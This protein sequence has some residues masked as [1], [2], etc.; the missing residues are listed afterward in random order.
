MRAVRRLRQALEK[1]ATG[2][3]RKAMSQ[4]EMAYDM[5]K[6]AR[7]PLHVSVIIERI[8]AAFGITVDRESV[9]SSLTKKVPRGDRFTRTEKNTFG[10]LAER[11]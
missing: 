5:L 1:P 2:S 3:V 9:V 7:T 6:K 10:L 8:Q 4:V 11:K